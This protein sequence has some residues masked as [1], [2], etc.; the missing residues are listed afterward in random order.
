MNMLL[1]TI[2]RY[3]PSLQ[4]KTKHRITFINKIKNNIT[5]ANYETIYSN[6]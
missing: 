6:N 4:Y 5:N 3:V 1:H 2:S